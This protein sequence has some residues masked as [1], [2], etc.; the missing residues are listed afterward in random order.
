MVVVGDGVVEVG[1]MVEVVVVVV[2]KVLEVVFCKL[3][4]GNLNISCWKIVCLMK[5]KFVS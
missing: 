5:P 1:L 3:E 4:T 2:L